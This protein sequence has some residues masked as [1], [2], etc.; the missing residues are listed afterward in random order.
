MTEPAPENALV[1]V[2]NGP[3]QVTASSCK[4]VSLDAYQVCVFVCVLGWRM[5]WRVEARACVKGEGVSMMVR[6]RPR[7]RAGGRKRECER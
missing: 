5:Q 2:I 4:V 6:V 1:A 7:A 3:S